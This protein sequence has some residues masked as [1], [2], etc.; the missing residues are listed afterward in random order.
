MTGNNQARNVGY[1]AA[2][3]ELVADKN[4]LEQ[5]E[6]VALAAHLRSRYGVKLVQ[7]APNQRI[8]VHFTVKSSKEDTNGKSVSLYVLMPDGDKH[9]YIR[10]MAY[11]QVGTF[12][13]TAKF[14]GLT[15][16]QVIDLLE[17][18][19]RTTSY[20]NRLQGIEEKVVDADK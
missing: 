8:S 10:F 7:K 19:Q 13:K 18:L 17:D 6:V 1:L 16:P 5:D 15:V 20:L 2:L 3:F 12:G 11:V 9:R 4:V 14:T